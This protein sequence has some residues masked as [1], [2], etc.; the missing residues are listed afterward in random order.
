MD[1]LE[2]ALEPV[3]LLRVDCAVSAA[4]IADGVEGDEADAA[5]IVGVVRETLVA[6][7]HSEAMT[8]AP[9]VRGIDRAPRGRPG[10][11]GGRPNAGP[12]RHEL[13]GVVGEGVHDAVAVE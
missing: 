1:L 9:E 2:P 13:L 12:P 7:L 8:A 6:A 5:G 11:G 3:Q 4:R 10:C